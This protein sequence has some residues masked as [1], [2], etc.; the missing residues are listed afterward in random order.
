MKEHYRQWLEQKYS[1]K[2]VSYQLWRIK[3]VEEVHGDLDVAYS[4]GR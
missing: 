3:K 2:T 4:R 1:P